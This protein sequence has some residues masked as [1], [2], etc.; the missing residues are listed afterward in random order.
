MSTYL[1]VEQATPSV[2]V[3]AEHLFYY[4]SDGRCYSL[5]SAGVEVLYFDSST[6]AGASSAVAN[7]F[8]FGG[9]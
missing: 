1:G 5:N 2:P 6:Y 8:W 4:K 3:P 7:Q 9:I